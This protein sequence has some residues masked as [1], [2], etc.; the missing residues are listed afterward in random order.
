MLR[1]KKQ[2]DF[3]RIFNFRQTVNGNFF[4]LKKAPNGAANTRF[5]FIASVKN[6]PQAVARHRLRRQASEIIWRH[7]SAIR[8]GFDIAVIIKRAAFDQDYQ[9]LEQDLLALLAESR[10]MLV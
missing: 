7:L 9:L 10:L 3:D 1:L 5:G 8:P 6:I 2:K 4:I